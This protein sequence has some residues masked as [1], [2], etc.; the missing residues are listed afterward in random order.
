LAGQVEQFSSSLK[1]NRRPLAVVVIAFL[2]AVAALALSSGASAATITS[3]GPL[4]NITISPDLNCSVNHTGDAAS[5]WFAATACGTLA[6]DQSAA[7]LYGPGSIPAGGAASPRTPFTQISQTGPTGTGTSLDPFKIVTVAGLGLSG[8][9][10][11]QTDTYVV[12]QE[13]YLTDVQIS[14][15]NTLSRSVRLYT[16]GDCFLQNSDF[17]FGRVDGG[18]IACTATADPGSRIEQLFPLTSGSRYYETFFNTMWALIGSR[19]AGP[20]TCDCATNEDNAILLSWDVSVPANGSVTVSH[21]TTFSP[22]GF[23]PL[24]TAKTADSST[25]TAGGADGYTIT[26]HNPN[27]SAVTV[28]SITDTLPAGF[29]YVPNS[30]TG[31]TTAN[32]TINGQTLT[33]SGSFSDAAGGDVSVHFNVTASSTAGTYF[34]NAGGEAGAVAVVPTGDT[35]PVTVQ[36]VQHAPTTLTVNAGSGDFADATS[37]SAVLKKSSDSTVIA[38]K[39]VTLT[40]NGVETCTATTDAT[41]TATCQITPGEAAGPYTLAGSFAGDSGFVASTG[42][43]TFNVTLEETALSYTGNTS[44]VNGQPMTLSGVLTTDDPA[45]ATALAGKLITFTLGSVGGTQN[46]S[47]TTDATGMASCQIPFVSQTPGPVA[48]SAGFAGDSFYAPASASATADVVPPPA[49]GAF[50]VGDMSAGSPTIDTA[51]NFWGA[52]WAK[53]NSFSGGAA[54]AAMKGFADSPT[55]LS[56]GDTWTTRTGNSSNAPSSIPG[57]INVIVSD[58]VTQSGS[59]ISGKILHVVVVRVDPGYGP[60]PGKDGNGKIIGIIC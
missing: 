12:G 10:I 52:Q 17:G 37:V 2:A 22:L 45:A 14:N 55:S 59:T 29:A 20:N 30:T 21:L 15:S 13:S 27:V 18:A 31:A 42:S 24:T 47:A 8:L 54:P 40:L 56:C 9:T 44:V 51:V 48:V 6:V 35:A 39:S 3:A 25:T 46:C 7:A 49:A 57:E 4:T 60:A 1:R 38:G 41:G 50:V 19:A 5:E 23:S 43:A 28:N 11:T 53:N 34:N 58:K 32:P 36:G 16:A 26:I 33:W